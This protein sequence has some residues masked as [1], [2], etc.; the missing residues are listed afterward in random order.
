ME[1][2][3]LSQ[4]STQGMT[5]E[6]TAVQTSRRDPEQEYES[7]F[8]NIKSLQDQLEETRLDLANS[9]AERKELVEILNDLRTRVQPAGRLAD[10]KVM[11][12]VKQLKYNISDLAEQWPKGVPLKSPSMD[13]KYLSHLQSITPESSD[14][15]R[16]LQDEDRRPQVVESFIWKVLTIEV[17]GLFY[18]AGESVAP[19]IRGLHLF[20]TP[21][22]L[23]S[24]R[25]CDTQMW[26]SKTTQ[27]FFEALN[28]RGD[29][30]KEQNK[31]Y[32]ERI[33]NQITSL[34]TET[35][36]LTTSS[37]GSIAEQLDDIVQGAIEL[38]KR[39]CQQ[40]ARWEWKYSYKS[41]HEG[42]LVFDG[43]SMH[44]DRAERFSSDETAQVQ[45]EVKFV[46]SPALVKR[47]DDDGMNEGLETTVMKMVVSCKDT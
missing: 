19:H 43:D 14:Y 26:T 6:S 9:C 34:I 15:R 16:L 45:K 27:L 7:L 11:G 33:K 30:E 32:L 46:I 39:F 29:D 1:G 38:D 13:H 40:A 3:V 21:G 37:S 2:V 41:Y 25:L 8:S 24:P 5:R 23:G 28:S 18:W 36:G 4:E 20:F 42:D 17:C 22:Q 10:R 12:F 35:L 47:G 44:S 31:L